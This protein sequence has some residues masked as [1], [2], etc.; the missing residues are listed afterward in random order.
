MSKIDFRCKKCNRALKAP[1][2]WASRQLNCPEC[3]T[4]IQVP[5][6]R[7]KQPEGAKRPLPESDPPEDPDE[8]AAD[9]LGDAEL[10]DMAP[11][12]E[13]PP[14]PGPS[15]QY[16][17][18]RTAWDPAPYSPAEHPS[19]QQPSEPEV[20][21]PTLRLIGSVLR[22]IGYLIFGVYFVAIVITIGIAVA[23]GLSGGV[24]MALLSICISAFGGAL[25]VCMVFA[26]SELIQVAIDIEANTRR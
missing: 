9:W 16:G 24:M 21:Y 14:E 7:A 15:S 12:P 8:A 25:L 26:A 11:L 1:A 4:T 13:T 10:P 22:V 2:D 3:K 17:T 6:A 23:S 5:Q 19:T 18:H 20:K